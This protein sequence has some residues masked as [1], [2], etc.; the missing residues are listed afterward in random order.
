[1]AQTGEKEKTIEVDSQGRMVLPSRLRERLG[2]KK[3]GRVSVRLE[4]S[5]V[6]IEPKTSESVKERVDKWA[7]LALCNR[8]Q[9]F[10][11]ERKGSSKSWKWMSHDYARRKL[12]LGT[13]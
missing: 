12:G 13:S 7:N 2:L 8:A 11:E 3:G 9:A 1:M 10:S 5:K 4:E 6:V